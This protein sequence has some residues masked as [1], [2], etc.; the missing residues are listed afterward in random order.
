MH[1]YQECIVSEKKISVV[2]P[3]YNVEKYLRK[4]LDSVCGQTFHNLEI[5]VV[6]DG[7]TDESGT[8]CD[9]YASFDNRI[10]VI[11][12]ENGG[13]SDARN[14]GMDVATGDYIG[15]VDSDDYIDI[16]MYGR[17]IS[18]CQKY[19]LDLIVA[20]FLES[21]NGKV[22]KKN[23]T[24]NFKIFSGVEVLQFIINRDQ[25]YN[26]SQSVWNR[27]YRR[28]MIDEFRFPKGLNY[29]DIIFSTKVFLK[30]NKCGYLDS[31]LYYYSIRD[32]GIMGWS[33]KRSSFS[34]DIMTDLL[35]QMKKNASI[36]YHAGH[37]ELGDDAYRNY[38]METINALEKTYKRKE[39]L[40]YYKQLKKIFKGEREWVRCYLQGKCSFRNRS[41][42]SLGYISLP[43]LL[44][45]LRLK[46]AVRRLICCKL[47]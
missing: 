24:G 19:D 36:I 41:I 5:I 38:I 14:A 9:Q 30:A 7:S 4:C 33:R 1:N 10:K 11:H 25:N 15:F 40:S 42:L 2:I 16:E 34:R 45:S 21:R 13:L 44:T 12:K 27:L 47:L 8:I 20:R 39:C 17:L 26:I 32:D 18:F 43:L 29:E 28:E 3:V 23:F 35:P 22:A 46:R 6:D 37:K 31:G